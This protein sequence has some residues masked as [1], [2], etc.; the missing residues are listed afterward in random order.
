[1]SSFIFMFA[2][3][4]SQTY[5]MGQSLFQNQ[6]DFREELYIIDELLQ[7]LRGPSIISTV[8][9]TQKAIHDPF[10]ILTETHCA[11]FGF[12][13]ALLKT[14][15]KFGLTPQITFGVSLGSIAAAIASGTLKLEDGASAVIENS[16]RIYQHAQS[17]S[18]YQG[19]MIAL[20]GSRALV[21]QLIRDE[22]LIGAIEISAYN[23]DD[24]HVVSV[25]QSHI[26]C[27]LEKLKIKDIRYTPLHVRHPFHTSWMPPLNEL[28]GLKARKPHT[29]QLCTVSGKILEQTQLEDTRFLANM[30]KQ[31]IQLQKS[32]SALID[33]MHQDEHIKLID[34]SPGGTLSALAKQH[35]RQKKEL[36]L[37]GR[38][39]S[40][41]SPFRNDIEL[42][43]EI[44]L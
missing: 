36:P 11:I 2:G 37:I 21:K 31:P 5:H 16:Q 23:A 24:H 28:E 34:L 3:Q 27:L 29:P 38:V 7:D 12:K 1:M 15:Q 39:K 32:F 40:I 41:F 6:S 35:M 20:I 33:L 13:I 22:E 17:N 44:V 14:L 4:G 42:F 43:N 8:Y 18:D 26:T 25:K 10:D 30:F 9:N 19:S